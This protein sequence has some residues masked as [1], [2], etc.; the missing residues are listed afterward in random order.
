MVIFTLSRGIVAFD[1]SNGSVIW[2]KG[3]PGQ[4]QS[5]TPALWRGVLFGVSLS[6]DGGILWTIDLKGNFLWMVERKDP[7]YRNPNLPHCYSSPA[8]S[9]GRVYVANYLGMV[10]CVDGQKGTLLWQRRHL[11]SKGLKPHTG[12]WVSSP[13]VQGKRLWMGSVDGNLYG[14]DSQTGKELWHFP[15]GAPIFSSPLVSQ[16]RIYFGG[17][18]GYLYSLDSHK[19]ALFWRV[20]LRN[21]I[22]GSPLLHKGEIFIGSIGGGKRRYFWAVR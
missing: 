7:I 22:E 20:N 12:F 2:K 16:D 11:D 4:V 15:T 10:Y 18:S 8:H 17:R 1:A 6:R 9:E 19:G 3:V 21:W 5:T 13:A 14:L